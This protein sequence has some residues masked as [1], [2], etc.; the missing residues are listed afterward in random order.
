M[1]KYSLGD[2]VSLK[3]HPHIIAPNSKIGANAL[4]APPIMVV[5]EI[6]KSKK[7]NPDSE[8]QELIPNQLLCTFFNSKNSSYEK[9]WFKHDEVTLLND[10]DSEHKK[11]NF[12]TDKDEQELHSNENLSSL[13]KK[14]KNKL[15]VLLSADAELRKKKITWSKNK[16][17]DIY[18]IEAHLEFLPPVMTVIDV[19]ENSNYL[20]ERR[21]PK[22]GSL[23]KDSSKFLLKC[24]WFNNVKQT[25][26][27]EF[28]PYKII[29]NVNFSNE[30]LDKIRAGITNK[31][32]FSINS[33]ENEILSGKRKI[34]KIIT[35]KDIIILNHS[36]R[37]RYKDIFSN[38]IS[39]NSLEKLDITSLD[40]K[41]EEL[42]EK[43]YPDYTLTTYTKRDSL[44][45]D[46]DKFYKITYVDR[47]GRSTERYIINAELKEFDTEEEDKVKFIV[48]DCLLRNGDLRHFRLSNISERLEMDNQF[49]KF[50]I[51]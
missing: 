17:D 38:K 9:F 15:V 30:I 33:T 47:N 6:L 23:R 21:D 12:E 32:I 41:I 50:L 5:T 24:K 7:Y 18:K 44:I 39:T 2:L 14:F 46:K 45:W 4:S 31:T 43:K 27:E 49:T 10:I 19:L 22:D 26:S 3:S 28:I 11:N 48:A 25:F 29:Q 16:E 34:K 20:K 8:Y 13:K 35:F 37:I 1:E 51:K 42:V 36:I 40:K